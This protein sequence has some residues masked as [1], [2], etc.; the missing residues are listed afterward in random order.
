M[1]LMWG[2]EMCVRNR[3]QFQACS[4]CT[5][6]GVHCWSWGDV[7][8]CWWTS[9]REEE[10]P[11]TRWEPGGVRGVSGRHS[12]GRTG[13]ASALRSR[14]PLELHRLVTVGGEGGVSDVSQGRVRRR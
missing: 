8:V 3:L 9:M 1:R 14:V 13:E 5:R 6:V 12:G 4:C 11:R 2:M 10:T 7:R